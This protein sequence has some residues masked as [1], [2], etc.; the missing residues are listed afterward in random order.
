V[1]AARA[2]Y[3]RLL[4]PE[5]RNPIGHFRR[6]IADGI[7]RLTSRYAIP[8][9]ERLA[10]IQ[11]TPWSREYVEVGARSASTIRSLATAAGIDRGSRVLDFG[12]GSG[13]TIRHL[14]E[15]GWALTGCDVDGDAIAWCRSSLPFASFFLSSEWPP[16]EV[17]DG[18]IDAVIAISVF[19]HFSPDAQSAWIGEL[20]RI[21]RPGGIALVSTMGPGIIG[22]FPHATAENLAALREHGSIY[23]P[24]KDGFNSNAAFHSVRALSRLARPRF[25]LMLWQEQGLDG[26]QDI[27]LL[28]RR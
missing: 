24:G 7:R 20:A 16:V 13:R 23:V 12:C 11:L 3:H 6:Q 22:N 21:L 27:S 26:F 18:S 19:T 25:D 1:T 15:Q 5:I 4:P 10:K 2:L 14:K 9:T 17:P 8:P 28:R